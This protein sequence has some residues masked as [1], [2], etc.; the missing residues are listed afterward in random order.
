MAGSRIR[1]TSFT[2][3]VAEAELETIGATRG[4]H[5]ASDRGTVSFVRAWTDH[6]MNCAP[7]Q[8]ARPSWYFARL[9]TEVARK[10]KFAPVDEQDSREWLLGFEFARGGTTAHAASPRS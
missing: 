9:A 3:M 8:T 2:P 10:W 5:W 7:L 4:P 1:N 6:P